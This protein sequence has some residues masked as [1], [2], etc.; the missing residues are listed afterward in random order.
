MTGLVEFT[1]NGQDGVDIDEAELSAMM[2]DFVRNVLPR[3]HPAYAIAT[4]T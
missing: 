2:A 1:V 3:N 4:N